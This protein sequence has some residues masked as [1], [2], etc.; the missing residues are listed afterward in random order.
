M[1]KSR[2]G[3]RKK[4]GLPRERGTARSAADRPF[5]VARGP[6]P[7]AR[8]FTLIEIMVVVA[9]IAIVMTI[10]IPFLKYTFVGGEGIDKAVRDVKEACSHARANAILNGVETDLVIRPFDKRLEVVPGGS[11]RVPEND[12]LS[13]PSVSGEE[14]RMPEPAAPGGAAVFTVKLSDKVMIQGLGVNGEDWTED[15]VA[16]VRFYP[17]GTSDE[18]S[19][20]LISDKMEQ[21]NVWLEVVT[22]LADV[23]TDPRNFKAR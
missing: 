14:W 7:S 21:R 13:S 16:R 12:R 20:V 23:E 3:I 15:E 22:G 8:A 1:M 11:L 2:L 17:N 6:R 9:I 18:M 19:L 4:H 10:G 5:C